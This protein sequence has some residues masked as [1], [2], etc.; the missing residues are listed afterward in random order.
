MLGPRSSL[1]GPAPSA[2]GGGGVPSP[3]QMTPAETFHVSRIT[4]WG[5]HWVTDPG[6]SPEIK[7]QLMTRYANIAAGSPHSVVYNPY[8]QNGYKYALHGK[9]DVVEVFIRSQDILDN[10]YINGVYDKVANRIEIK[11][12][13]N[14]DDMVGTLYHETGHLI[15]DVLC[16]L[17]VDD[18]VRIR[19]R[20][21]SLFINEFDANIYRYAGV[22]DYAYDATGFSHPLQGAIQQF[23]RS[24]AQDFF[25]ADLTPREVVAVLKYMVAHSNG[26]KIVKVRP[27]SFGPFIQIADHE[28]FGTHFT[29]AFEY[30]K[31]QGGGE[32]VDYLTN[33]LFPGKGGM[34]VQKLKK[35]AT[36]EAKT[37][38]CPPARLGHKAFPV[39]MKVG[40][41]ANTAFAFFSGKEAVAQYAQANDAIDQPGQEGEVIYRLVNGWLNIV[42]ILPTPQGMMAGLGLLGGEGVS[43]ICNLDAPWTWDEEM[44]EAQSAGET[45]VSLAVFS[46]PTVLLHL[47]TWDFFGKIGEGIVAEEYPVDAFANGETIQSHLVDSQ[48][49]WLYIMQNP[50]ETFEKYFPSDP[51]PPTGV[52]TGPI[53]LDGGEEGEII[54][55]II[56]WNPNEDYGSVDCVEEFE[57]DCSDLC[58]YNYQNCYG[59]GD[60]NG[61]LIEECEDEFEVCDIQCTCGNDNYDGNEIEECEWS[62][63]A[64][65]DSDDN[66]A[67]DIDEVLDPE[68]Y[69]G[70]CTFSGSFSN[71]KPICNQNPEIDVNG[72]G[73]Q[74]DLC[75]CMGCPLGEYLQTDESGNPIVD[76]FGLPVCCECGDFG[77][78]DC[79]YSCGNNE[80]FF[81]VPEGV[82]DYEANAVCCPANYIY[83]PDVGDCIPACQGSECQAL[84]GDDSCDY[85]LYD[86][87]CPIISGSPNPLWYGWFCPDGAGCGDFP[88]TCGCGNGHTYWPNPDPEEYCLAMYPL[89][90]LCCPEGMVFNPEYTN[91]GGNSLCGCWTD[92]LMIWEETSSC[93]PGQ[94]DNSCSNSCKGSTSGPIFEDGSA[95]TPIWITD[96]W[97]GF[98][99]FC[100]NG[101]SGN[102]VWGSGGTCPSC[103]TPYEC[104]LAGAESIGWPPL[105]CSPP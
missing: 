70:F 27:G 67:I 71:I 3:Q 73:I 89:L 72:D 44:L 84:C 103:N 78:V 100:F 15:E 102:G 4:K 13:P 38:N 1:W 94:G 62:Y 42:S 74:N 101:W 31:N 37:G 23:Y 12:K 76:E 80:N 22:V 24:Q 98:E 57:P 45:A 39:F 105:S 55:L 92:P 26:E 54:E 2:G 85:C 9:D 51:P 91:D 82:P 43:W 96:Q 68:D 25:G 49:I 86:N 56:P 90:G 19:S 30:A 75:T 95:G 99:L 41:V 63:N 14:L 8:S 81:I 59:D 77:G 29:A 79:E 65:L 36:I 53:V 16:E 52:S 46:H 60:E 5:E 11:L 35:H 61:D 10:P 93:P 32:K 50:M 66:G 6:V 48:Q 58:V 20:P 17:T 83:N 28:S 97:Y 40:I 64:N 87:F 18:I 34:T 47:V 104:W 69:G 7:T 88:N 21:E 33:K